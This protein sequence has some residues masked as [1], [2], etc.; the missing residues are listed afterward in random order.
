MSDEI[1]VEYDEDVYAGRLYGWRW[2]LAIEGFWVVV[3]PM[4]STRRELNTPIDTAVKGITD[5][6]EFYS[7]IR[8]RFGAM[9]LLG[10]NSADVIPEMASS[11]QVGSYQVRVG[12]RAAMGGFHFFTDY[13]G[14]LGYGAVPYRL[15]CSGMPMPC[16][17]DLL[18]PPPESLRPYLL[19]GGLYV[20]ASPLLA[21]VE[22][23]GVLVEHDKGYRAQMLRIVS[24]YSDKKKA[25]R[26]ELADN[27]GWPGEIGRLRKLRTI[28]NPSDTQLR[29]L[30]DD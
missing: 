1:L 11:A 28:P 10:W 22:G 4:F 23:A 7:T 24:L 29:R 15:K 26:A 18:L 12:G 8:E 20:M 6:D 19:K 21:F 2:F 30:D 9:D 5:P 27:L 25:E 14:A 13:Q 16:H 3:P 17:S